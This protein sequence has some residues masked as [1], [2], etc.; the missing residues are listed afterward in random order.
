M[1]LVGALGP[2]RDDGKGDQGNVAHKLLGAEG[3]QCVALNP[4]SN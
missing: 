4:G 1:S 3:A 2:T